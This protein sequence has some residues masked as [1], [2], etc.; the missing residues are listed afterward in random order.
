ML[1]AQGG[2]SF[3]WSPANTILHPDS[4]TTKAKPASNQIYTVEATDSNGC[5]NL[6]SISVHVNPNPNIQITSLPDSICPG[7]TSLIT[8]SG[9]S[10]ISF[11]S[12]ASLTSNTPTSVYVSDTS[13]TPVYVTGTDSNGCS[14][15]DTT[16]LNVREKP[17]LKI[18]PSAPEA[19]QNDSIHISVKGADFY[20]WY[21]N[22]NLITTQNYIDTS[23]QKSTTFIVKGIDTY[24]CE[25][26][27]SVFIKVHDLPTTSLG[28]YKDTICEGG[29]TTLSATGAH[30]YYWQSAGNLSSSTSSQITASPNSSAKYYVTG[31][32]T[33]GCSSMDSTTITVMPKPTLSVTPG[34]TELCKGDPVKLKASG[35]FPKIWSPVNGSN[36]TGDSIVVSPDSSTYYQITTTGNNGCK[37]IDTA[38]VHILPLPDISYSPQSPEIC[39]GD[40]VDLQ[41][42]SAHSYSIYPSKGLSDTSGSLIKAYP[43]TMTSYHL[44]GYHANGCS[45]DTNLSV[46]VFPELQVDIQ[47]SDTSICQGQSVELIASGAQSYYW[48]PGSSLNAA[49]NDTVVATPMSTTTYY[50]TGTSANG[51]KA[52][53]SITI[54]VSQGSQLSA[55]STYYNICE[56]D[57]IN[58]SVNGASTYDW[59]NKSSIVQTNGN[60]ATVSPNSNTTYQVM[61][62]DNSNCIHTINIVVDV[63]PSP[64]VTASASSSS[65]CKNDSVDLHGTGAQ[66]YQW[67]ANG[68]FISSQQDITKAPQNATTYKVIGTDTNGC[69]NNDKINI[70]VN[71]IPSL[72]I[73]LS[74]STICKGN[75]TNITASG[76]D[77]YYW[78][79]DSSLNSSNSKSVM[80]SPDT[81]TFYK[82]TGISSKGCQAQDSILL[83]VYPSPDVKLNSNKTDLCYG[84]SV[85]LFAS[86]ADNYQWAHSQ[87]T[88]DSITIQPDSTFTYKVTGSNNL[89][90]AKEATQK[91][92]VNPLPTVDF[93]TDSILCQNSS[94]TINNKTSNASSFSW[95]FGDNTTSNAANPTHSYQ[96]STYYTIKLEASG[97]NGCVDSSFSSV[98]VI[99]QPVANFTSIPDSGCTPLSVQY[100]NQSTGNYVNYQWD[101]GN[102]TSSTNKNPGNVMYQANSMD[103]SYAV[104]LTSTNKCGTDTKKD[105]IKVKSRPKASFGMSPHNGCS[106]L[107]VQLANNSTGNPNNF[108]WNFGDGTTSTLTNPGNHVFSYTGNSDTTYQVQLIAYNNCSSDTINK[109]VT[110]SP[111]TVNAFF[112]PSKN[113]GC[114]PL[115]VNFNNYSTPGANMFWDF[116]DGNISSQQNPTHTFTNPGNYSVNLIVTDSC[117]IDTVTKTITVNVPP[118]SDFSMSKD[119][120]CTGTQVNFSSLNSNLANI[121]WDFDDGQTSSLTNPNHTF[122]QA[123]THE[124]KMVIQAQG[125]YCKDSTIK[126]LYVHPTPKADFATSTIAG[127]EPL[128]VD[129]SDSSKAANYYLYDFGNGNSSNQPAPAIVYNQDGTFKIKLKVE[130]TYGCQD[131]A[132][133]NITVHPK[134]VS[135]FSLPYTVACDTPASVQPNNL[136]SG[137]TGYEW[138]FDNGLFSTQ[139]N[140]TIHYQTPGNYNISLVASNMYQ[141]KDTSSMKFTVSEAINPKFTLD[142]HEG[143]E[144]LTVV[145][146]DSTQNSIKSQWLF[147][148]N[149]SANNT[150]PSHTYQTDGVY[151]VKL[152]AENKD[153]CIDSTSYKDTI[154][155]Y[156][157]PTVDFDY[158]LIDQPHPNTGQV[159]F[160]AKSSSADSWFWDFDDGQTDTTE[161]PEHHFPGMGTYNVYLNLSN[162]YG[163]TN[164]TTKSININAVKSLYIPNALAPK[165]RSKGVNTFKPKGKGLIE[166][167]ITIFDRWGNKI[168]SSTALEDGQ[169]AEGWDGTQNGKLLPAGVYVWKVEAV[170]EDG[171]VWKGKKG[172]DGNYNKSGHVTL[173]R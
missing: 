140:P 78:T 61:G 26:T 22:G 103:T 133:Q 131:S 16:M 111:Q 71:P 167:S 88:S 106:P 7:D 51:C 150:H 37:T 95:D 158:E 132:Q 130:N 126:Q 70:S 45:V 97:S 63:K 142:K 102:G 110:V 25:V 73:S 8:A 82:V 65:I 143:C 47:P 4:T 75:A 144:P 14:T 139:Q 67:F 41:F 30:S 162:K 5:K 6:D 13:D 49:T 159:V 173:I 100:N 101:L 135:D 104:T 163:C 164:D 161:N 15:T 85:M 18:T 68:T 154:K 114:A 136:S 128:T 105:T 171:S 89:G 137:A 113:Q 54:D 60:Q 124:I 9:A 29:S 2:Y 33:N 64:V 83:T 32:D 127:C 148:D 98:Q 42:S 80:A 165:D 43:D 10:S 56:G 96:N 31:T 46:N 58:L 151:S 123:G 112:N 57:T 119:T 77:T 149:Q 62:T 35:T 168:W 156:P 92:T 93:E 125:T 27:D 155:V 141:C 3:T 23:L 116:D 99:E 28:S 19:C 153:G 94:F 145:F 172:K 21:Y 120:I 117:S 115:T 40:T 53:D 146:L 91:I 55:A 48:T 90:C 134:P 12:P 50:L 17:E 87:S 76:A 1:S 129:I 109:Q 38:E 169:P 107:P 66:N 157:Q 170:F 121:H 20:E 152:I 24:G 108:L 160:Y 74:D 52:K 44:T 86:G 147:G 138:S 69:M 79:P 34:T 84:D 72:N 11:Q 59:G 81:T 122:N 36:Y 118:V 39:Y 166:Y